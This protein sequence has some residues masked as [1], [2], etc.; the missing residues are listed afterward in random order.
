MKEVI[1]AKIGNMEVIPPI[2]INVQ[3]PLDMC[4]SQWINAVPTWLF[5]LVSLT[6]L[7]V[8]NFVCMITWC[9]VVMHSVL[10]GSN[11]MSGV[12]LKTLF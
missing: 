2:C 3:C 7:A 8:D 12:A 6:I 5:D 9:P 11:G 4:V 10:P 1:T